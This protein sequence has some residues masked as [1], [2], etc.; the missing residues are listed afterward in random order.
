LGVIK[1]KYNGQK[2]DLLFEEG[3]AHKCRVIVHK[4]AYALR[5]LGNYRNE[6]DVSDA[7]AFCW[8]SRRL[9]VESILCEIHLAEDI[10]SID[11]IAHE[12]AHAVWH[13]IRFLGLPMDKKGK[14]EERLATDIGALTNAIV[15]K[16]VQLKIKVMA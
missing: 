1:S 13:R 6:T 14:L 4:S 11:D 2:F 9:N 5:R 12:C 3:N 8:Q 10:L 7:D 15:A 16:L